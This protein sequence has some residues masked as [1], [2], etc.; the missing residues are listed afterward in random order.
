MTK[1]KGGLH[2]VVVALPPEMHEYVVTEAKDNERTLSAQVK[3]MLKQ[4]M[5]QPKP[6]YWVDE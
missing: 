4:V 2:R 5:P 6:S 1:T 3:Y